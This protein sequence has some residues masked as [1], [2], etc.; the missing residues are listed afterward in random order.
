T[1]GAFIHEAIGSNEDEQIALQLYLDAKDILLKNYNSYRTF[2]GKFKD[3][4]SDF[5][6]LPGM[7]IA[8]VKSDYVIP[9]TWEIDLTDY[10]DFKIL[11]MTRR[12]RPSDYD[13]TL[14]RLNPAVGVKEKLK[15]SKFSNV[16]FVAQHQWIP[17]KV[18][19]KYYF[20]LGSALGDQPGAAKFGV[21]LLELFAAN[22]LGL[23]PPGNSWTP[24]SAAL[25]LAVANLAVHS[26]AISFELPKIENRPVQDQTTLI[27][28]GKK[29][30]EVYQT[31]IPVI[32]PMGDIAEEAVAEKSAWRATRLG[33][34]LALKHAT[35]IIASFLT[36]QSL[37]EKSEFLAKN[38]AVFQYVAAAKAIE[39]SELADTR[40]WSSLPAEVRMTDFYLPVG[41]Y[42]AKLVISQDGGSRTVDL[43][44][45]KIT[46]EKQ[47]KIIN[48]RSF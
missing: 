2:N 42:Q 46:D 9:T 4:K 1:F 23:M 14:G 45:I 31:K 43:G 47:K 3:F 20:S 8:K 24:G 39:S 11:Q 29:G 5:S 35:A 26:A 48:L 44:P 40:F 19:D 17:A 13:K 12:L 32:D 22:T 27:I 7:P 36:Y 33:S 41:D 28:T 6:K 37:K 38:A 10:L 15:K 16:A 34:R 21:G 18:P 25:G 30:Q